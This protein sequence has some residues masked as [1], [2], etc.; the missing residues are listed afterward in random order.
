MNSE[1]TEIFLKV[2]RRIEAKKR[3]AAESSGSHKVFAGSLSTQKREM[4]RLQNCKY[5][6]QN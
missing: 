2:I 4:R 6:K 3:K 5:G 1:L